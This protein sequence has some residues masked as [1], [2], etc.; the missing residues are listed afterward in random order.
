MS[1]RGI[2]LSSSLVVLALILGAEVGSAQ[3]PDPPPFDIDPDVHELILL[4]HPPSRGGIDVTELVASVNQGMPLPLGF[5]EG[6]P[7]RAEVVISERPRGR[8]AQW[9]TEH[10]DTPLGRIVR[11]TVMVYE[12]SV[13]LSPIADSL[14]RNPM[15]E[16]VE[17]NLKLQLLQADPCS[18]PS[19]VGCAC[20]E[21]PLSDVCVKCSAAGFIDVEECKC[22]I[23]LATAQPG[24]S[25]GL[26]GSMSPSTP[27]AP[28]VN[29]LKRQTHMC[30][31]GCTSDR[32]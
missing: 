10:P 3:P 18:S 4:V 8:T 24:Q 1:A 2:C 19:S 5:S 20:Q 30:D 14:I 26:L 7:V 22:L 29:V 9:V 12:D 23:P 13:P 11:Y 21:D 25:L 27:V 32:P 16:S 6:N 15:I 17:P 28:V 31:I